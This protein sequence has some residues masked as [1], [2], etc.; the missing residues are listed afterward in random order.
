MIIFLVGFMGAGKSTIGQKLARKWN[1][2]FIDTDQ[3]IENQY[4]KTIQEM[5]AQDGEKVFRQRETEALKQISST[6]GVIA[7]GGGIVLKEENRKLLKETGKVVFL[8]CD[9]KEMVRRLNGDQSRPLIQRLDEEGIVSLYKQ[10]ERLYKEVAHIHIDT[11]GLSISAA[12][13]EVEKRIRS[14][15]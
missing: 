10:R 6:S 4:S 15:S 1:V 13:E 2:P 11:T 9:P 5:F 7:T 8:S 12:V 3:W 14:F